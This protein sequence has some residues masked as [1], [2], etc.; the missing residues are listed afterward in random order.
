VAYFDSFGGDSSDGNGHGTH[1]GGTVAACDNDIDVVGVA[2]EATLYAVR[3]LDNSGKGYD[4]DVMAGLQWVADNW[5]LVTP[6][7][8]VA[9]MSLGRTGTIGDNPLL[10]AAVQNVVVNAGVTVV[11]SAGNDPGMEI[12]QKVTAS[13]PEV[14]AIASTTAEDG[15]NKCRSYNGIIEADTASWFTTDGEP[16]PDDTDNLGVA[17]SAP[18]EQKENI[19]RRCS[20]QS[21]G[22]LSLQAGGGT[23]RGSGTSMASPHV[24]GVVALMMQA[25]PALLPEDVRCIVQLTAELAG[26]APHGSPTNGYTFDGEYEGIIDAPV[27]V[28]AAN[29]LIAACGP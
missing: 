1:V 21:I 19:S 2:H 22:I 13:Y 23:T 14:M 9:N 16:D 24:T 4:S 26:A 18:G 20:A 8:R 10:R 29:P 25:S 5:N 7:I 17:I 28:A 27:A 11:V 6:N 3:V 15:N 12:S